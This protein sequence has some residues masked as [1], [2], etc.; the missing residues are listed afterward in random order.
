MKPQ[1]VLLLLGGLASL[2]SGSSE[3]QTII[4]CKSTST[5]TTTITS[6]V[7]TITVRETDTV[8]ATTTILNPDAVTTCTPCSVE[9]PATTAGTVP[10]TPATTTAPTPVPLCTTTVQNWN[11]VS[12]MWTPEHPKPGP[13]SPAT[14]ASN[15]DYETILTLTDDLASLERFEVYQ[16]FQFIGRTSE[17][18]AESTSRKDVQDAGEAIR[19]GF[20][21]GSFTVPAGAHTFTVTW[22]EAANN[23]EVQDWSGGALQYRFERVGPCN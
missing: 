14:F 3:C 16:D 5:V 6:G 4:N 1:T 20:S 17:R 8:T 13:P 2:A 9:S 19:L 10:V 22:Q 15:F 11:R 18:T 12:L 21:H 7:E 23:P